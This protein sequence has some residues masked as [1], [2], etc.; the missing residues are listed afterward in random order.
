M[1]APRRSSRR[2]SRAGF[3]LLEL[4]LALALLA[5]LLAAVN[6]FV[7]SMGELWGRNSERRLFDQHVRAVTRHVEDMLRSA[8]RPS[9]AAPGENPF[10]PRQI[11][12]TGGLPE[13]L[14]TFE[15]PESPRLATWA[16]QPLPDV[17]CCLLVR[18]RTG[19]FLGYRSR[20]ELRFYEDPAK[21]VLISPFVTALD[22]EYYQVDFNTWQS[23]R[24]LR[25]DPQGH[26]LT[27]TRLRLKFEH[28]EFKA[29]S[30]ILLP[31]VID[32]P[33]AY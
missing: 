28:G 10:T 7:F 27:P 14:L 29:E 6:L 19:L 30:V 16:D 1:I 12:L 3:T 2:S 8:S 22:Y 20:L 21:L 13:T 23:G 31:A 5:S 25:R 18:E 32:G 24:E 26:W 33:P 4:L 11:P 15:L 9:V 17:Q